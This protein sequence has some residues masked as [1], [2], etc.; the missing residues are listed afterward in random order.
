[1]LRNTENGP[2]RTRSQMKISPLQRELACLLVFEVSGSF[3]HCCPFLRKWP[4]LAL[5]SRHALRQ[6]FTICHTD[7]RRQSQALWTLFRNHPPSFFSRDVPHRRM[8]SGRDD[9]AISSDKVAPPPCS[10]R[11]G[12]L[13]NH[14]SAE[15]SECPLD[16]PLGKV[17]VAGK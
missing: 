13:H 3:M 16:T 10:S 14:L 7:A 1:M 12:V 2:Q 5:T 15:D 8:A 9:G 17:Y 11:P 6:S 4:T